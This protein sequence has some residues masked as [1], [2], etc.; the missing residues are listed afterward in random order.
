MEIVKLLHEM[1][2]WEGIN[3]HI[4]LISKRRQQLKQVLVEI[5]QVCFTSLPFQHNNCDLKR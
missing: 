2:D 5:V 4:V 3:S 1:K